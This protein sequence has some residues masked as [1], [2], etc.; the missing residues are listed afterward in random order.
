MLITPLGRHDNP[1][2]VTLAEGVDHRNW[3]CKIGNIETLFK[4]CR[5]LGIDKI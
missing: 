4:L 1:H 5:H 2:I 3:C